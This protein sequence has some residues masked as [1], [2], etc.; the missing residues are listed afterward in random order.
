MEIEVDKLKRIRNGRMHYAF[1]ACT[2]VRSGSTYLCYLNAAARKVLEMP[3]GVNWYEDTDYIVALP[4]KALNAY[5]K[6]LYGGKNKNIFRGY[7]FPK[8]LI[9]R[10][11]VLPGTYK[12]YKYRNGFGFKFYERLEDQDGQ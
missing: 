1:P 12:I 4:S 5:K 9:Q 7:T 10:R 6:N 11:K 8:E 3:D 2:I